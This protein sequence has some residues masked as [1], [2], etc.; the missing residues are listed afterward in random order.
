MGRRH[1]RPLVVMPRHVALG[2]LESF[3]ET[4][5]SG[6]LATKGIVRGASTCGAVSSV[7]LVVLDFDIGCF[8][9]S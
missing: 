6:V 4:R 2:F 1:G 5:D 3:L 7:E 8:R 9:E